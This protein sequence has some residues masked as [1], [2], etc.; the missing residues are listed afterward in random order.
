LGGFIG[1]QKKKRGY[2]VKKKH[3]VAGNS[4]IGNENKGRLE[5]VGKIGVG[6]D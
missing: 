3:V 5:K 4:G 2:R 1:I 6:G